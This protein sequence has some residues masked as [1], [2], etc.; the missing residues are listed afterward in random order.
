M[1]NNDS[2]LCPKMSHQ[3]VHIHTDAPY[4]EK[5]CPVS[6]VQNRTC[7]GFLGG[8]IK[9][10]GK[11]AGKIIVSLMGRRGEILR[12]SGLWL[13]SDAPG[14]QGGKVTIIR[15]VHRLTRETIIFPIFFP[16]RFSREKM[17]YVGKM[18]RETTWETII[19]PT[20]ESPFCIYLTLGPHRGT[21]LR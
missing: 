7:P 13:P 3:F 18:T 1:V 6:S 16:P 12:P 5:F 8:K 2:G 10:G 21:Q 15:F 19:F 11:K 4:G 9:K 14:L 20:W 17:I